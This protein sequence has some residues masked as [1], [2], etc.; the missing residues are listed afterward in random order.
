MLSR[1][2]HEPPQW[3]HDVARLPKTPQDRHKIPSKTVEYFKEPIYKTE[4]FS[5]FQIRSIAKRKRPRRLKTTQDRPKTLQDGPKV[6]RRRPQD[7]SKMA[8]RQHHKDPRPLQDVT[9]RLQ[10]VTARIHHHAARHAN[11]PATCGRQA[12]GRF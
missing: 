3:I 10:A 7:G 9:G 2:F 11:P 4:D 5:W 6:A 1:L 12:V 8:P